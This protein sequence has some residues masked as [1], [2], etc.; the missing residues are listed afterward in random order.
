[1]PADCE[2]TALPSELHPR[3]ANNHTTSELV[4]CNK[5]LKN[6]EKPWIFWADWNDTEYKNKAEQAIFAELA[7]IKWE[8]K[9]IPLGEAP[10]RAIHCATKADM[11]CGILGHTM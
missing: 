10:D 2:P 7:Q 9:I 1:M 5:T 3:V 6:H 8:V 4:I 11:L